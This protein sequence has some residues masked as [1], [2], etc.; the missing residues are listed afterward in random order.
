LDFFCAIAQS[1]NHKILSV[2]SREY[3][4]TMLSYRVNN[5]VSRNPFL[6][7]FIALIPLLL[8]FFL[9]A[10]EAQDITLHG[11]T[12]VVLVPTLVTNIAGEPIFGLTAADFAIYDNGVQQ[13]LQL[14]EQALGVPTSVVIAVQKGHS[15]EGTL[16][17]V[18]RLGSLLYPIVGEGRGE[19]AVV[20]F[21][22]KPELK[23]DFTPDLDQAT[24]ILSQ[25]APGSYGSAILDAVAFS[26]Q[27]LD[28]RPAQ[29]RR[30]LLLVSG[31]ND[32]GSRATIPEV[33]RQIERSN[34]L[35][36]SATYSQ[37]KSSKIGEA[38]ADP[39][40]HPVNLLGAITGLMKSAKE[41]VPKTVAQMSGGEYLPFHDEKALED[42]LAD[43]NNHFF[44]QY[45]LSFT[46]KKLSS[47]QHSLRV[48]VAGHGDF[49]VTARTGYWVGQAPL[50]DTA[51]SK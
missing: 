51:E 17:K 20:A 37:S 36:Y 26:V 12:S 4:G 27:M 3:F 34:I 30:V 47:G 18:K 15:A 35:I 14:D 41:N 9:T 45:L 46:P 40:E 39:T 2:P 48:A 43:V 25:I 33:M 6:Y 16:D 29:S 28:A 22:D 49:V 11:G 24:K 32:D 50:K 44:N 38:I 19:V 7:R 10:V 13:K 42:E 1:L 21:D 5:F 23:Q 31:A 8:L